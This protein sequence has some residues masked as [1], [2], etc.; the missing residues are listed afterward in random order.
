ML[1]SLFFSGLLLLLLLVFCSSSPSSLLLPPLPPLSSKL[2]AFL[3]KVEEEEEGSD[4]LP[5]SKRLKLEKGQLTL[6][7]EKKEEQ[8]K[9][10]NENPI[11]PLKNLSALL[12]AARIAKV[13]DSPFLL[14]SSAF[15]SLH[16]HSPLLHNPLPPTPL[17]LPCNAYWTT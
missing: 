13:K 5:P 10:H 2:K 16:S 6:T 15:L 17:L 14:I 7:W 8:E 4:V 11:T 9:R 3:S 1:L 12:M